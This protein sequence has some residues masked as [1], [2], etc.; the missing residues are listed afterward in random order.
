VYRNGDS[1]IK[2]ELESAYL[3]ARKRPDNLRQFEDIASEHVN[4]SKV[5]MG[6]FHT[7][8]RAYA[9]SHVVVPGNKNYLQSLE[10]YRK[11]KDKES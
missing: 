2:A 6:D 8:A 11:K 1:S 3:D 7:V 10:E 9:R 5:Y 4:G